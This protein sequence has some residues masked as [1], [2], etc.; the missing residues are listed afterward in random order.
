MAYGRLGPIR[1]GHTQRVNVMRHT[2]RRTTGQALVEFALAATLIFMLLSAAVD[3]GLLFFSL[4]ALRTAAQEGATYG[5]HPQAWQSGGTLQAVE[6]DYDQIIAR[7]RGAA[8]EP[9]VGLVNLHDLNN[10]GIDDVAEGVVPN[11]KSQ[12]RNP[13]TSGLILIDNPRGNDSSAFGP[14]GSQTQCRTNVPRQDMRNNGRGCWARVRLIYTY[15]FFFPLAP[16][17]G[18]KV[19]FPVEFTVQVDSR[20]QG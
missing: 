18:S 16:V 11:P 9:S 3:L 4:Q 17:F 8:G 12:I 1:C 7:I 19:T 14:I 6:L 2:R 5:R 20:I 10:N 15:R 13:V